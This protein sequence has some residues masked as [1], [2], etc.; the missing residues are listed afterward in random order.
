MCV[1]VCAYVVILVH[2]K[3][4]PCLECWIAGIMRVGHFLENNWTNQQA[5]PYLNGQAWPSLGGSKLNL[6][7]IE[8]QSSLYGHTSDLT[9]S[10]HSPRQASP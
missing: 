7:N 6:P 1:C 5:L 9:Y 10:G 3:P 2:I 4:I 8:I